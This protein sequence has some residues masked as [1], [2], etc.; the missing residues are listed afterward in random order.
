[1]IEKAIADKD[2]SVGLFMGAEGS[3]KASLLNTYWRTKHA[4]IYYEC[5]QTYEQNNVASMSTLVSE[6]F[7][8]SR[9]PLVVLKTFISDTYHKEASW[10]QTP[11]TTDTSK[12]IL[13]TTMSPKP[14]KKSQ[15]NI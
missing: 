7:G 5:K 8:F 9:L 4:G 10:N 13:K 15:G 1:M 3:V 12:R 14:L 11:F 2:R 6:S